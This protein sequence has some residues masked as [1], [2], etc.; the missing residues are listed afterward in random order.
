MPVEVHDRVERV[1]QAAQ[2]GCR[3]VEAE[4][5]EA[6][7]TA[8]GGVELQLLDRARR[9][10]GPKG[11][12]VGAG[13]DG[14]GARHVS[15]CRLCERAN[16]LRAHDAREV[17]EHRRRLA[18]VAQQR[19]VGLP[20]HGRVRSGRHVLAVLVN[21]G[22]TPLRDGIV[23]AHPDAAAAEG[24]ALQLG[25]SREG[26]EVLGEICGR[27]RARRRTQLEQ[28]TLG[29]AVGEVVRRRERDERR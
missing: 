14:D 13:G 6:A 5:C 21:G 22:G 2:V 23:G 15:I 1:A 26:G 28:L 8:A 20:S 10:A 18:A 3:R 7:S 9:L 4:R 19:H 17:V 29:G 11:G 25:A 12:R 27:R 24:S 16:E